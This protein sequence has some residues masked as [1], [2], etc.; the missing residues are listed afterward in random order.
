MKAQPPRIGQARQL[1]QVAPQQPG[2]VALQPVGPIP[3]RQ[4]ADLGHGSGGQQVDV[5]GA[6][7]AGAVLRLQRPA[8]HRPDE[9]VPSPGPL[10]LTEA[11]DARA[12]DA[13][14]Q[15]VPREL[16]V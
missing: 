7:H 9:V 16:D 8:E 2:D 15:A 3:L 11:E 6:T 10:A 4:T 13:P 5:I 1:T 12:D 14:G